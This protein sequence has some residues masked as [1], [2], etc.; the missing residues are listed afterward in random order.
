MIAIFALHAGVLVGIALLFVLLVGVVIAFESDQGRV[1]LGR[2]RWFRRLEQMHPAEL[3]FHGM[4]SL[5][6]GICGFA[7]LLT[8][9]LLAS[10]PAW[11]ALAL[12]TFTVLAVTLGAALLE[13]AAKD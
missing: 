9:K 3:R 10:V 7:A 5:G 11:T 2:L 1:L 4:I 8:L 12:G 6:V 13:R